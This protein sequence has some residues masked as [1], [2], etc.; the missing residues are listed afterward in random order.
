MAANGIELLPTSE[1]SA[2]RKSGVLPPSYHSVFEAR[3]ALKLGKTPPAERPASPAM[4][5]PA[6]AHKHFLTIPEIAER[7]RIARPTVYDRLRAAGAKVL[8]FNPRGGRGRKIIPF[9]VVLEIENRRLK[10]L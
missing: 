5:A 2:A 7:W 4:P 8:D 3:K 9:G 6:P 10:R 1:P